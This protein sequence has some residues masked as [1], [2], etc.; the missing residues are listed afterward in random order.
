LPASVN[1]KPPTLLPHSFS[2]F[3]GFELQNPKKSSISWWREVLPLDLWKEGTATGCYTLSNPHSS[4]LFNIWVCFSRYR[5]R[6]TWMRKKT[7][8]ELPDYIF[9]I[10]LSLY[11]FFTVCARFAGMDRE[12]MY[13]TSRNNLSY[14]VQVKKFVATTKSIV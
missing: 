13:W 5:S 4:L 1:P 8:L 3:S 10:L 2:I 12:W 7:D 14:L 9:V 11:A 6:S